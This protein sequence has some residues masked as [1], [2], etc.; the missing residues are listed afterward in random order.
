M[1]ES[2]IKWKLILLYGLIGGLILVLLLAYCFHWQ[3]IY[4]AETAVYTAITSGLS[5]LKIGDLNLNQLV[6][7]NIG[8]IIGLGITGVGFLVS[9]L[10][11]RGEINKNKEL[12]T[13]QEELIK[14]NLDLTEVNEGA[15]KVI[16]KQAE[17]LKTYVDDTTTSQLQTRVNSLLLD[18]EKMQ[19]QIS[20][21]QKQPSILAQQL[22]SKSGG[23]I[24]EVGNEKYKIIEKESLKV[25]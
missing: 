3:P 4:N 5:N 11:Y 19:A 25:L 22:W 14:K 16:A 1:S 21:L 17:E 15:N 7:N 9:V 18:N 23:Q 13:Q 2:R 12:L 10:K 6:T 8:S 20:E 24:I